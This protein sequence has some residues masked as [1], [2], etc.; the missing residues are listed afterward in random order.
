MHQLLFWG[1]LLAVAITFP[2]VFG[3]IHF[4]TAPDNQMIY[5]AHLFGFPVASFPLGSLAA[6]MAFNGLNISAALVLS[7]HRTGL[8][9]AYAR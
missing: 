9:A 6:W 8:V 7:R 4:T 5:I 1:C 2:L 3:W